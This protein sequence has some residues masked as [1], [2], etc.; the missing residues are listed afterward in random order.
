MLSFAFLHGSGD[1]APREILVGEYTG[2]PFTVTV[3]RSST[4]DRECQNFRSWGSLDTRTIRF[5]GVGLKF[6]VRSR[7]VLKRCDAL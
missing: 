7:K 5:K 3:Y 6:F 1:R 4:K 2:R